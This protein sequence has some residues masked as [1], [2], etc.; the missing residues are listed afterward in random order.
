MA[1]QTQATAAPAPSPST[2]SN[3]QKAFD[4]LQT[5]LNPDPSSADLSKPSL[6]PPAESSET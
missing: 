5:P 3:R 4:K 6:F 2:S 1:Y